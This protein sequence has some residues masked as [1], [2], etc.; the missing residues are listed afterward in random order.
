MR[1]V[2]HHVDSSSIASLG[3]AAATATLEVEFQ[4]GAVYRYFDV[5]ASV[6]H[7]LDSADSIGRFFNAEVRPRFSYERDDGCE[8]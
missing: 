3:Y 2:R 7:A 1:I 6:F 5:P 4:G 8:T